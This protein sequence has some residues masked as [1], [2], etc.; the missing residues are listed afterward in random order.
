MELDAR[1]SWQ[2]DL[3]VA[4]QAN[5]ADP[6]VRRQRVLQRAAETLERLRWQAVEHE[7]RR[8]EPARRESAEQAQEW[9]DEVN[10]RKNG[11]A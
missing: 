3:E 4:G 10:R 5:A 11:E 7:A 8:N 9:I 1:D 6:A 2:P